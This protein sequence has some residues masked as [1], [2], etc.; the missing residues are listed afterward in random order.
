MLLDENVDRR[1]KRDFPG[2]HKVVT[3][4]EAGWAGKK[5]G[6][7]VRLAEERFDLLPSTKKTNH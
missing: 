6:E 1:P 5:N 7:L 3:V 2:G 4:A